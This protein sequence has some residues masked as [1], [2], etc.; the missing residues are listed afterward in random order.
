MSAARDEMLARI[1]RSLPDVPADERP[2]TVAVQRTYR[3]RSEAGRAELVEEFAAIAGEYR[4]TVR[5]VAAD[6]LGRELTGECVR[7]GL[8]RIVVPPA[9]PHAWRPDGVDIVED[10][11]LSASEL[12][13]IDGAVT[14]CA[15]AIAQTGTLV[16]DGRGASGRRAITLVPDHHIC[17]VRAEQIVGLVPEAIARVADGVRDERSPITLVSGPSATSDIELTRVE[18]VHGPRHLTIAVAG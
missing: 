6:E 18:G 14:G 15:V 1:R 16:L 5:R 7:L 2:D 11:G 8:H 3:R 12:D 4:A 13:Q 17:V 10:H 9:L